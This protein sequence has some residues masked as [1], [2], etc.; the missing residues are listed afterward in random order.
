MVTLTGVTLLAWGRPSELGLDLK[1]KVSLSQGIPLRELCLV[2][3]QLRLEDHLT[4]AQQQVTSG[5]SLHLVLTTGDHAPP[6]VSYTGPML[7]P[8]LSLSHMKLGL[9]LDALFASAA[10]QQSPPPPHGATPTPGTCIALP[11][12]LQHLVHVHDIPYKVM[13]QALQYFYTSHL[14]APGDH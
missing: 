8:T 2:Y 3:Q 6:G 9:Q 13:L 7:S 4:L 1:L 11:R 12:Q 10:A 5:S 14:P